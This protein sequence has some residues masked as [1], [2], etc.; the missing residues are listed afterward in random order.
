LITLLDFIAITGFT[1]SINNIIF[2]MKFTSEQEKA[3]IDTFSEGG[4]EA[5]VR[6]VDSLT[7]H[8]EYS[9]AEKQDM[10]RVLV[11]V[12]VE[13]ETEIDEEDADVVLSIPDETEDVEKLDGDETTAP[14]SDNEPV[15]A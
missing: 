11:E 3:I 2:D 15:V 6:V 13:D 7:N 14:V 10:V 9:H 8:L 1:L 4:M 12:P 5:A